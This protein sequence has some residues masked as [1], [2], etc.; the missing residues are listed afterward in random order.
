MGRCLL[1]VY[2]LKSLVSHLKILHL[3]AMTAAAFAVVAILFPFSL[4]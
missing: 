4:G 1:T 3:L 2:T